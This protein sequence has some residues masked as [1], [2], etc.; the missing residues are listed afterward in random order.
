MRGSFLTLEYEK[1]ACAQAVS[2]A[3][4]EE[5]EDDE[6]DLL[7]SC[8]KKEGLSYVAKPGFC[9]STHTKR[10]FVYQ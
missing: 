9:K 1:E 4:E 7:T 3:G 2:A 10:M 5:D 6:V 8:F